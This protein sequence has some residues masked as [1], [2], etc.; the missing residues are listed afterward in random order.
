M[1][2][3]ARIALEHR[4]IA[5][6]VQVQKE[7]LERLKK[8]KG[9]NIVHLNN[10]LDFWRDFLEQE[11]MSWEEEFAFAAFRKLNHSLPEG[12]QGEHE[13]IRRAL[14]KL[15]A[16]MK[17]LRSGRPHAGREYVKW[18]EELAETVEEHL[19]R[20]NAALRELSVSG[21][22]TEA[23]LRQPEE[24]ARERINHLVQLAEELC[25]EYLQK[26]T[27]LHPLQREADP[28]H[29]QAPPPLATV[30]ADT[31]TTLNV[32]ELGAE[33]GPVLEEDGRE[34]VLGENVG[35]ETTA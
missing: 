7:L 26:E 17:Q 16:T 1:E 18:G 6:L 29:T 8:A 21:L 31:E 28:A 5:E 25:Q 2:Y 12:L 34:F 24:P 32:E 9:V 11:H 13:R 3:L 20:E 22:A 4:G 27:A 30:E 15:E 14:T 23:V 10:L 19:A 35:G 33:T